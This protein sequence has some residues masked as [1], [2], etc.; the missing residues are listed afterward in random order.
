MMAVRICD[1]ISADLLSLD[2]LDVASYSPI[3]V[4]FK[5]LEIIEWG[6]C[7]TMDAYRKVGQEWWMLL[8]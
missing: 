5:K 8:E 1:N 4:V 3:Y 6:G 7:P 2:A